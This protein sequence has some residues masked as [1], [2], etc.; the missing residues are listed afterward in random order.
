MQ[1]GKLNQYIE[2]QSKN[3][4]LKPDGSGDRE[5]VWTTIF[6]I[7]GRIA[8]ASVRDFITARKEQKVIATRIVLRQ[9]DI[10]PN[11]DWTK[12]RLLCDGL[13]YRI[14]APLRDNKTGRE[15]ITLACELGAYTWQDL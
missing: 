5:T 6:P 2:V 11:T 13:Y 1:S 10:E 7:Y 12:C 15:Y 3:P 8:D 14:I 4:V 9:D